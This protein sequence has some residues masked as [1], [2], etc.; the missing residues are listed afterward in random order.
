MLS[1]RSNDIV[2]IRAPAKVNL[3]LEVLGQ[4][5]DG[6]HD[7]ATLMVT[8]GLYDT[9]ELKEECTRDLNLSIVSYPQTGARSDLQALSDGPDNLI[10]RAAELLRKQSRCASGASIRLHKRIPL[11]A[12]L[13]GGSSNAAA[14]L[15]GLNRLWRLGLAEA[16]LSALGAELGSDVP[17]FFYPPAAWCTGRGEIVEPIQVD[18]SFWIVLVF[19]PVGLS[20]ARVFRALQLPEGTIDGK[21]LCQA[22]T[23]GDLDAIRS[24]MH[25]RLQA[26][27]CSL[28]PELEEVL[29]KLTIVA[30]NGTLMSG[31]GTTCFALC[32][33]RE[34]ADR[35]IEHLTMA[36]WNSG[37]PR[38]VLT[39][40]C[41]S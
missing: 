29:E 3:F 34:E 35:V 4:R 37:P 2:T 8:V 41:V 33:D 27:A 40:A 9:L 25:N 10:L 6:Y 5:L 20:T 32:G 12:G 28:C 36:D 17:F 13:A 31:S 7:L 1:D 26:T 11:A 21:A 19:P 15:S 14:T 18:H 16:E 22:L 23:K 24:G 30:P 38:T 39:R